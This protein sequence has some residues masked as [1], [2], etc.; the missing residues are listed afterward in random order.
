MKIYGKESEGIG[1][2]ITN[3]NPNIINDKA[4]NINKNDLP[5]FGRKRFNVAGYGKEVFGYM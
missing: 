2:K 3:N 5:N 1:E 4:N